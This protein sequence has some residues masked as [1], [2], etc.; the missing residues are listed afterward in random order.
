MPSNSFHTDALELDQS[1]RQRIL[2]LVKTNNHGEIE[3][4]TT[5]DQ[6]G[7]TGKHGLV[8]TENGDF[9]VLSYR[10][11]QALSYGLHEYS[12]IKSDRYGDKIWDKSLAENEIVRANTLISTSDNGFALAGYTEISNSSLD[13]DGQLTIQQSLIVKTDND[14]IVEW[15]ST[16][17]GSEYEDASVL[18]QTYD[19]GFVFAGSG[20]S[21]GRSW[22]EF[23]TPLHRIDSQGNLQWIKMY[24]MGNGFDNIDVIIQSKEGGFLIGSYYKIIKISTFGGIEWEY[25]PQNTIY[26]LHSVVQTLDGDYLIAGDRTLRKLGGNGSHLW[27]QSIDCTSDIESIDRS[28]EI[29][30][31]LQT[32]DGNFVIVALLGGG[33]HGMCIQKIDDS[34]NQLWEKT[35][36]PEISI[37]GF[38]E[39]Q[40][41]GFAFIARSFR[42][43]SLM[44]SSPSKES[45]NFEE[46]LKFLLILPVIVVLLDYLRRKKKVRQ[47][48][49]MDNS[50]YPEN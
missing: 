12:L 25:N 18:V 38:I 33:F 16:F 49:L 9:V 19:D 20:D 15:T 45:F 6:D 21:Y 3:W 14:G 1:S 22:D 29:H 47:L 30:T 11:N 46:Y 13:L 35:Y 8:Q 7:M 10:Y 28:E 44:V 34:G 27:D 42:D 2:W 37:H 32:N 31:L 50:L 17:G 39:T 24:N 43:W 48:R 26:N 5:I 4:V 23:Q 36:L 41:G 40:D